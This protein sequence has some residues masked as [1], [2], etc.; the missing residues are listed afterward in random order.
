MRE[1]AAEIG[2][3]AAELIGVADVELRRIVELSVAIAR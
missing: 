1:A 3:L 2:I